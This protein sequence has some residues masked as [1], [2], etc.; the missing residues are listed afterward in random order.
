MIPV[1]HLPLTLRLRYL[2]WSNAKVDELDA[3]LRPQIDAAYSHNDNALTK[4]V[5][6]DPVNGTDPVAIID[7]GMR[8]AIE[9][10]FAQIRAVLPPPPA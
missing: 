4:P 1:N 9:N 10:F 2:R 6:V 5:S 3:I 8:A 7:Q